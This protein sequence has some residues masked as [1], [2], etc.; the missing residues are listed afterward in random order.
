MIQNSQP[1][2][3]YIRLFQT[4]FVVGITNYLIRTADPIGV[5]VVVFDIPTTT[6]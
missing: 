2:I 4:F 5:L 6:K 3:G 1:N